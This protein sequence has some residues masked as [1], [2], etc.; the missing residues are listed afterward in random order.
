[1]H[2]ALSDLTARIERTVSQR[3][4]PAVYRELNA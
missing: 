2:R 4:V 1:M 3:L